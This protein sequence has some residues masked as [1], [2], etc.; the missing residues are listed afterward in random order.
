MIQSFNPFVT[1]FFGVTA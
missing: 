1:E